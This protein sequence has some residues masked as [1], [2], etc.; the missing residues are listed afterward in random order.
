VLVE[1]LPPERLVSVTNWAD[2]PQ[3]SNI[4]GRVP[5]DVFRFFKADLEKL[6]ALGPDLVVVSEYTDADFL[7]LLERSGMRSHRMEGLSSLA[8]I[9]SAILALGRAAGA[10]AP[11][12]RLVARY[13]RVLGD[14][15][16][17]LAGA[18]RPR[19]LYWSSG[20]TAGEGTTIGAL[21]EAAG[22]VNVGRELG[23]V[24][25]APP[26]KERVFVADPDLVLVGTW[27]L[28]EE[29]LRDDA[30]LAQMRAVRERHVI[31]M[32]TP[33]LVALSQHAAEGCWYLASRLHP[34]RVPTPRPPESLGTP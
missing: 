33:L 3:T 19:V 20:M 12:E 28:A 8:G 31:S 14:L 26:G 4:A 30:L 9:R 24:G 5:K 10:S 22:G 25:I 23:V 16:T 34:D 11:A 2:E 17:R 1:I 27:P 15:Q 13:D 18:E 32:P 7:R 29:S 6:V 21:I